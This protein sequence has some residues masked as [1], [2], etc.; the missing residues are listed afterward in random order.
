MIYQTYAVPSILK[1]TINLTRR[2][3]EEI[4]CVNGN[5]KFTINHQQGNVK[6]TFASL[7]AVLC[8]FLKRMALQ[9]QLRLWFDHTSCHTSY[10]IHSVTHP[11]LWHENTLTQTTWY[12][13]PY[14]SFNNHLSL[15]RCLRHFAYLYT[16]VKLSCFWSCRR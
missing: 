15:K 14:A 6:K 2:V 12:R 3:Y 7:C 10:I 13:D 5:E 9:T 16:W 1:G 4:N 11:V 8:P